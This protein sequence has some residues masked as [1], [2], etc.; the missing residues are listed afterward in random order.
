VALS[1]LIACPGCGSSHAIPTVSASSTH[2]LRSRPQRALEPSPPSTVAVSAHRSRARAAAPVNAPQ[3]RAAASGPREPP[4]I[5]RPI[6][7]GAVRRAQTVAYVRRHYGSFMRP[8][9]KLIHPRV[10][11]IHY[12]EASFSSTYNTFAS[13]IPDSELHELP[14]TCAQ[15]VINTD[16]RIYQ[17]VSLGTMCRHAVGLNWTAIGIEHVGFSDAQVLRDR[18]QATSSLRLVRWLRCRFDIQVKNVIG[19]NESLSS[20]YHRE[21][22]AALRT[23]THSDFNHADMQV[24]RARLRKLGGCG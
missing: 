21:D 6:P 2:A 12:T 19:H 14:A 16:G 13:D 23:Q 8:T 18:R 22:V 3:H 11:V 17:L 5:W 1:L 10:I 15:F 9:S 24:Y 4:V 7:F 20:P